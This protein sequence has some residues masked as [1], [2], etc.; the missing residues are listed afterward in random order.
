MNDTARAWLYRVNAA[1]LTVLVAGQM[2]A[3]VPPAWTSAMG[4]S[5]GVLFTGAA[6]VAQQHQQTEEEEPVGGR[7]PI[8]RPTPAVPPAPLWPV[9]PWPD[10]EW[11]DWCQGCNRTPNRRLMAFTESGLYR[12]RDCRADGPTPEPVAELIA[13]VAAPRPVRLECNGDPG[14]H[15]DPDIVCAFCAEV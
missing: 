14:N 15:G 6:M 7:R 11:Y 9:S 4:I 13:S 10:G 1:V 3:D 2:V 8:E 5:A 12:C